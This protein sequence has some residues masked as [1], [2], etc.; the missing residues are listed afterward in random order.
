MLSVHPAAWRPEVRMHREERP[1][2]A[3]G[4]KQK[5]SLKGLAGM[6]EKVM[7]P[8]AQGILEGLD[9]MEGTVAQTEQAGNLP[10]F[11]RRPKIPDERAVPVKA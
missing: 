9:I 3:S 5:C 6:K 7:N 4:K 11:F 8:V 1:G 2:D 10:G